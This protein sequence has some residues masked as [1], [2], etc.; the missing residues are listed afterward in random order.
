[1]TKLEKARFSSALKRINTQMKYIEKNFPRGSSFRAKVE[2]F[3]DFF[4]TTKGGNISAKGIQPWQINKILYADK[5][6]QFTIT[7]ERQRIK[8]ALPDIAQDFNLKEKKDL[9]E[10]GDLLRDIKDEIESFI[11]NNYNLMMEIEDVKEK[12]TE[13][14]GTRKSYAE[15]QELIERTKRERKN[16]PYFK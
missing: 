12:L 13:Q 1:M 16:A 4:P 10:L 11:I 2:E 7:G 14:T 15:L 9:I 6:E 8:E 3:K 5:K